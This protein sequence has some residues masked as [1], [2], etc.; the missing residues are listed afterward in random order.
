MDDQ[1]RF[2][3]SDMIACEAAIRKLG[4]DAGSMEEVADRIVRPVTPTSSAIWRIVKPRCRE[5]SALSRAHWRLRQFSSR[6]LS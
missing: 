5:V 2:A 4:K 3:L 1:M 6:M